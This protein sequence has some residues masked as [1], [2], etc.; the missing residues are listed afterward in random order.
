MFPNSCASPP[1]A[2]GGKAGAGG[3]GAAGATGG[4]PGAAGGG[5][6]RNAGAGGAGAAGATGRTLGA[7]GAAGDETRSAVPMC[8]TGLVLLA[9]SQPSFSCRS[10]VC[11]R[12]QH[13]LE[14][15]GQGIGD[16]HVQ[17]G[18]AR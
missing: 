4:T 2:G 6:G 14:Q 3:G 15:D 11:A 12:E 17:H 13:L 10:V 18:G 1:K 9:I 16:A 5:G 7:A 8:W